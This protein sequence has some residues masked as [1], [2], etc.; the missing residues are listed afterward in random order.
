MANKASGLDISQWLP[1][2][3]QIPGVGDK[4]SQAL[5]YIVNGFNQGM[6]NAGINAG[7]AMPAP[8]RIGSLSVQT[9]P[10]GFAYFNIQDNGNIQRN[11]EYF[12]EHA[13]NAAFTNAHTVSLGASRNG[14]PLYIGND[15][16]YFRAYS[17]YPGSNQTSK[18]I[19][20]GGTVPTA[21]T[22]GGSNAPNFTSSAGAGTAPT[23][24]SR[25]GEGFGSTLYRGPLPT[26]KRQIT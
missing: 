2:V 1:A 26:S 9:C 24:G 18:P 8:P 16:R 6:T 4:I 21:L 11:I 23:D 5:E 20:F 7:G 15:T 19:N 12:V 17:M 22:G 10:G 13:D 25:S 3:R 14:L